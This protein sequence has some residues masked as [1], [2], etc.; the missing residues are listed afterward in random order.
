MDQILRFTGKDIQDITMDEW[1]ESKTP[2]L[3][4][5]ARKWF[6]TMKN[7]GPDVQDIFHDNH[8]IA[9]YEN[10][11]F[12][13][14]NIFTKHVN[15]GFFYG[16][17]LYDESGLLEG[18]GKKMRHVKLKPDEAINQRELTMLIEMSYHDIKSRVLSF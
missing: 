8:P 15:V 16:T 4:A 6:N 17:D 2:I 10:A 13:Y 11:P 9:C 12:A 7:V 18:S 3:G 1:L 14:V 5:L